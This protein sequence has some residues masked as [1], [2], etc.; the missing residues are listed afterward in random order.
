MATLTK[1]KTQIVCPAGVRTFETTCRPACFCRIEQRVIS[2][3]VDPVS[4]NYHC[5]G[6]YT[7]CPT[8][9]MSRDRGM[10]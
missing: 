7:Q 8:W 3:R 1:T 10:H 2:S 6:Q 9:T 4:Y 5:T